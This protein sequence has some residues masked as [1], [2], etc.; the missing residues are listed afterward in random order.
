LIV[1]NAENA[2]VEE[3]KITR[4]LLSDTSV[5][6]APKA[7]FFRE[8]GFRAEDWAT[9]AS[10]IAQRVRTNECTRS[11]PTPFGMRY[12]VDGP[13]E[14]PDGRGPWIRTVWQVS[15]PNAA[16]RLITAHPLARPRD[17]V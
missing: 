16:P 4:Y 5:D 1:P 12:I 15:T 14:C 9:L 17:S 7:A 13:I 10:A 2:Y 6:G 11:E 8:F 3:R